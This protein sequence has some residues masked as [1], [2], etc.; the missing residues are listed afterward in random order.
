MCLIAGARTRAKKRKIFFDLDPYVSHVQKRIDAGFCEL[1]GVRFDLSPGRS[2]ASPSIDRVTP[3][4]G[5]I[6]SNIRIVCHAM[7]VAIGD[8]GEDAFLRVAISY[9]KKRP[10]AEEFIKA[11]MEVR[12]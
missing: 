8:W 2:Y 12:P 11:F 1:S 6:Y 5:Y 4:L 9:I 10:Q 3:E 7:N